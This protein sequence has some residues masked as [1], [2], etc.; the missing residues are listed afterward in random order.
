MPHFSSP[1]KTFAQEEPVALAWRDSA[2]QSRCTPLALASSLALLSYILLLLCRVSAGWQ[3]PTPLSN[4]AHTAL[5]M[6]GPCWGRD[7]GSVEPASWLCQCRL[8]PWLSMCDSVLGTVAFFLGSSL[9][10]SSLPLL[11]LP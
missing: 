10:P 3:V 5:A 2:P 8:P 6:A 7:G 1:L 4:A 11:T 9:I